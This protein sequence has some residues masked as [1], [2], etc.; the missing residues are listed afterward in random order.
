VS[1]TDYIFRLKTLGFVPLTLDRAADLGQLFTQ[2]SFRVHEKSAADMAALAKT[3]GV[4]LG[5]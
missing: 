1:E 2:G 5:L 3:S 4:L